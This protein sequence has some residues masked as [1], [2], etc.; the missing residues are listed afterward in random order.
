MET[1]RMETVRFKY[2]DD[3][4][5]EIE[6]FSKLHEYDDRKVFRESWSKW[7]EEEYI[8]DLIE[9]EISYSKKN[10]Y[11]GNIMDKMYK[12]A[13]YYYRKKNNN[14]TSESINNTKE[15]EEPNND[16]A[17]LSKEMIKCM[18]SHISEIIYK[19]MEKIQSQNLIIIKARAAT[20]FE[21]FCKNYTSEIREEVYRLKERIELIPKGISLKFKKA[22]KNRFYKSR[23]SIN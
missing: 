15:L 7:I 10:G 5:K 9:N 2:S 21:D 6:Y 22:Y 8:K 13:R 4:T 12:S 16:Y 11:K 23:L 18:D 19:N 14:V 1:V 3:F 17:G 20:A